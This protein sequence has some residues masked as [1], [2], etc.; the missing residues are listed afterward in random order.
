MIDDIVRINISRNTKPIKFSNFGSALLYARF[1]DSKNKN[2]YTFKSSEEVEKAIGTETEENKKVV[3]WA[4]AYFAPDDR[5]PAKLFLAKLTISEAQIG[6][7]PPAN[8]SEELSKYTKEIDFRVFFSTSRTLK[9]QKL[10]VDWVSDKK[11]LFIACSE[12]EEN[13]TEPNIELGKYAKDKNIKNV[14]V[15]HT[16][17]AS[18]PVDA[19]WIGQVIPEDIG[20]T[21][22]HHELNGI[23]ADEYTSS[24]WE[25]LAENN[26]NIYD[27]ASGVTLFGT[28][29]NGDF[30]DVIMSQY[31]TENKMQM[32]IFD[33]LKRKQ[34]VPFDDKGTSLIY[35]CVDG[36]F[37]EHT[38]LFDSVVI[39]MV[40]VVD[41]PEE[42]RKKRIYKGIS[43]S[44]RI[45]GSIHK[46]IINGFIGA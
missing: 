46:V 31:Y 18:K 5:K 25:T 4:K 12:Q 1:T 26:M 43:W 36:F 27:E 33:L 23:K 30:I 21:W 16:K 39:N 19:A 13:S 40:P 41:T 32:K 14:A 2:T 35:A 44:A 42:D 45:K 17:Q 15:I 9:E 34:R 3:D 22:A 8:I 37:E 7:N 28:T 29:A 38:N 10:M 20:T 6:P 11:Y 24:Q